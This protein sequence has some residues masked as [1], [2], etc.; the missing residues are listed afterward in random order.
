MIQKKDADLA[1]SETGEDTDVFFS[2]FPVPWPL[3]PLLCLGDP[4][5][6]L[7]ESLIVDCSGDSW[8]AQMTKRILNQ[9]PPCSD[10]VAEVL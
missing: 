7:G 6:F 3:F 10:L 8:A 2:F 5:G 4:L 9:R 1:D